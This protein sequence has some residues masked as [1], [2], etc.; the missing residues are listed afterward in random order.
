M[1]GV[2]LLIVRPG[3]ARDRTADRLRQQNVRVMLTDSLAGAAEACAPTQP[4]VVVLDLSLEDVDGSDACARLRE[5]ADCPIILIGDEMATVLPAAALRAGA[6][7]YVPRPYSPLELAAR[8]RA[9]LRRVKEYSAQP[10]ARVEL[11]P[12]TIDADRHE[13][14]VRGQPV[15]LAPKE[16]DLL[17]ALA[18]RPNE[19]L[20][21]DELLARVWGYDG[22][23][24]SRTLDVHVGR[25][26]RKI[27]RD[28]AHPE[29]VL[30]VPRLGYKLAA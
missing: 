13:V 27:E 15:E 21:R 2:A 3:R 14:L 20:T 18:S 30:T 6:D 25:L 4:D 17:F 23:A 10:R 5:T 11:G 29:L 8:V 12:L 26:R 7:D 22:S 9:T 16:F 28:R 19:L 1:I 24:G